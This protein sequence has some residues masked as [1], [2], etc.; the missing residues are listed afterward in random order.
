MM[1]KWSLPFTFNNNPAPSE[2]KLEDEA[3]SPNSCISFQI[4]SDP[5]L[6]ANEPYRAFNIPPRSPNLILAGDIGRL[7]DFDDYLHF[8]QQQTA[9]FERVFLVLE[10]H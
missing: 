8:L 6:E 10:N 7:A 2:P 9:R 5:Q 1:T 3:V 4:L